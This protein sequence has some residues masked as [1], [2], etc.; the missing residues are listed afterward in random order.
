MIR[1]VLDYVFQS[2][3]HLQHEFFN[4]H[5]HKYRTEHSAFPSVHT[6]PDGEQNAKRY[7]SV[8]AACLACQRC[9][10]TNAGRYAEAPL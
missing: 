1:S 9:C 7:D 8:G 10:G 6:A 4:A 3:C 2:A 5:A